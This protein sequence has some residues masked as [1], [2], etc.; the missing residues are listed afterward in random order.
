MGTSSFARLT[1]VQQPRT[2]AEMLGVL[3]KML[4]HEFV[5]KWGLQFE[6]VRD[7]T[8]AFEPN[9]DSVFLCLVA[10][11]RRK[12]N[13]HYIA[14]KHP[15]GEAFFIHLKQL[16]DLRG[17]DVRFLYSVRSPID[18]Y[19]S[20]KYRAHAW[21]NQRQAEET[22]TQWSSYWLESTDHL[23]EFSY[24]YSDSIR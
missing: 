9:W 19:L 10:A 18:T 24:R 6:E 13:R 11:L 15:G 20:H 5:G 12:E 17:E 22:P 3:E 1:G 7:L 23:L 16:I 21:V 4:Q 14:L 8:A 2:N